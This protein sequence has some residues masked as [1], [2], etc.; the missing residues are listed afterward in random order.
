MRPEQTVREWR[1]EVDRTEARAVS[2]PT[3]AEFEFMAGCGIR[4]RIPGYRQ[5]AL[6]MWYRTD[7]HQSPWSDPAAVVALLAAAAERGRSVDDDATS[8]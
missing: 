7:N 8:G 5:I 6:L 2:V 1:T 4:Y 3:R